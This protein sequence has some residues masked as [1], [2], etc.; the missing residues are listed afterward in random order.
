[1]GECEIDSYDLG[2][3]SVAS[4]CKDGNGPSDFIKDGEFPFSRRTLLHLIIVQWQHILFSVEEPRIV[5]KTVNRWRDSFLFL[6]SNTN[7]YK[8]E[9][10][11]LISE[12]SCI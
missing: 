9:W 10:Q 12:I 7:E 3:G 8:S 5:A 2:Y 6:A 11:V 4:S 1:V